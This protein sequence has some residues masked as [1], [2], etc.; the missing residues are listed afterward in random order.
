VKVTGRLGVG[1]FCHED[2]LIV[3]V[4]RVS[5]TGTSSSVR[6][7]VALAPLYVEK[8]PILVP[9]LKVAITVSVPSL[10]ASSVVF[11]ES[12]VQEEPFGILADA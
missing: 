3:T 1:S 4:G 8:P 6:L 2:W 9:P 5:S 10:R 11:I 7:I 12:V